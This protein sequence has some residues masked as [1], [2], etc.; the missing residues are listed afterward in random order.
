[1]GPVKI[2]YC[3]ASVSVL[4]FLVSTTRRSTLTESQTD[5]FLFSIWKSYL[6]VNS[7]PCKEWSITTRFVIRDVN[8]IIHEIYKG[9]ELNTT[10]RTLK[11]PKDFYLSLSIASDTGNVLAVVTA[12]TWHVKLYE[13]QEMTWKSN[14]S[15]CHQSI[16]PHWLYISHFHHMYKH[17]QMIAWLDRT[18]RCYQVA[19]VL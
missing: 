8:Y 3:R 6:I 7:L 1:M 16:N 12:F 13:S 18:S 10:P 19:E 4:S 15:R 11:E 14:I 2:V 17:Q 9:F 5:I